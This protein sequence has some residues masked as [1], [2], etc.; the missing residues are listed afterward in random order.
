M[1]TSNKILLSTL[2]LIAVIAFIFIC[3]ARANVTNDP[4]E[5]LKNEE[6]I[7]KILANTHNFEAYDFGFNNEYTLDESYEGISVSGPLS[8]VESIKM[9]HDKT[10]R[11]YYEGDLRS[12]RK[13][14][15]VRIGI[16]GKQELTIS[17]SDNAK[18]TSNAETLDITSLSAD[19]NSSVELEIKTQ[20]HKIFTG[21]NARVTALINS[22]IVSATVDGNSK[23]YLDDATQIN[24][25]NVTITGNSSIS[26]GKIE[27]VTGTLSGNSKLAL[28]QVNGQG[29][30]STSGNAK[31]K[32]NYME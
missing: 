5:L 23:L 8:A 15:K 21:G 24:T 4:A 28:E 13:K 16:K 14:L 29:N 3:I 27:N 32:S 25:L 30:V 19:G 2:A 10:L 9:G 11:L 17:A 26:G 31:D 1:K 12:A 7:E 18:V 22:P 20:S 6:V